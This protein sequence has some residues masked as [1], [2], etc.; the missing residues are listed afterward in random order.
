MLIYFFSSKE[1]LGKVKLILHSNTM[2]EFSCVAIN[3]VA[4]KVSRDWAKSMEFYS[5]DLVRKEYAK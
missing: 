3:L 4:V 5:I 1:K 2:V